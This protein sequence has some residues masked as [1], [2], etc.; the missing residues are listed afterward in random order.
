MF[1]YGTFASGGGDG[2]VNI[3]DGFN[4]KRLRQFPRYPSSIAALAFS[5]DGDYLAIAS[6]YCYEEGPK[7]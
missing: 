2:V 5:K 7:E 4:K 1:R 3:W 6:S